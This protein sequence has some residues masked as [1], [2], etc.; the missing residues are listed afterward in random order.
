MSFS[1]SVLNNERLPVEL[2]YLQSNILDNEVFMPG[3][4]I[5]MLSKLNFAGA[6]LTHYV[7]QNYI[8]LLLNVNILN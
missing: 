6:I 5:I 1:L 2:T 4:D 8:F 3:A 7:N